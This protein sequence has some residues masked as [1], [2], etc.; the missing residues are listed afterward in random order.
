MSSTNRGARRNADDFYATPAWAIDA[1]MPHLPVG[2]MR[3]LDAGAGTGAIAKRL[4][5][6]GYI[7]VFGV[8]RDGDRAKACNAAGIDCIRADFLAAPWLCNA[9]VMNPPFSEAEAFVRHAL[10]CVAG[11][12]VF[13]LLR[14]AFLEGRS[15]VALHREFPSDVFVL[16]KRPSFTGKGTDSAAYAWFAFGPGYG[17]RWEILDVPSKR[18]KVEPEPVEPATASERTLPMF[19]GEVPR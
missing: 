1:I 5:A 2:K 16:P 4:V 14:L 17:G 19:D 10:H 3:I 12:H 9:V 11:G 8:E 13:A 6:H 15:R 18:A 7:S